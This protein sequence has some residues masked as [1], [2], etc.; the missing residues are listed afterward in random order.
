MPEQKLLGEG[1]KLYFIWITQHA[2]LG[3]PSQKKKQFVIFQKGWG[4][5]A[6]LYLD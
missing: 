3:K 4:E 1:I 5:W 2:L 6:P